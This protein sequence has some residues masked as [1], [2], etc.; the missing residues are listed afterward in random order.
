MYNGDAW[1]QH[2][3][4]CRCRQPSY[5]HEREQADGHFDEPILQVCLW[6]LVP[7]FDQLDTDDQARQVLVCQL[8][9]YHLDGELT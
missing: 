9:P 8:A 1:D 7:N 5:G 2:H 4:T 3:D 6:Q